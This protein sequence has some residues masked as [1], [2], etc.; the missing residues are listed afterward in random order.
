MVRILIVEDDPTLLTFYGDLLKGEGY[1]VDQASNGND[2]LRLGLEGG[3]DLILMDFMLP[4][5]DG[6]TVLMEIKKQKPRQANKKIIL[7]TNLGEVRD[8]NHPAE[9]GIV[10][11]LTKSKLTPEEF[12]AEVKRIIAS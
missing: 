7:L 11:T 4:K 1:E 8:A 3:Y 6:L 12:I 2:A 5:K 10:K 9:L